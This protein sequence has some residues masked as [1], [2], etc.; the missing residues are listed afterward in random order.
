[1]RKYK[2]GQKAHLDKSIYMP[3]YMREILRP[4]NYIVTIID[5]AE[6]GDDYPYVFKEIPGAWKE[7]YITPILD[8]RDIIN[9]RFEILDL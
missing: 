8:P 7:K 6:V 3:E 4:I 1:M 9:S 5:Y 2:I